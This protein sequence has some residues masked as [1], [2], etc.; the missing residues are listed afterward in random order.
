MQSVCGSNVTLVISSHH[1][2]RPPSAS[3]TQIFWSFQEHTRSNPSGQTWFTVSPGNQAVQ[4]EAPWIIASPCGGTEMSVRPPNTSTKPLRAQLFMVANGSVLMKSNIWYLPM[5][6][7]WP[8]TKVPTFEK[9]TNF[10]LTSE[11]VL[12]FKE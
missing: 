12:S 4:P 8:T 9:Q 10:P 5:S 11:M 6:V 3:V 1:L 2:N 7:V